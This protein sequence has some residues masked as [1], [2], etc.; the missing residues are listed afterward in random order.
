MEPRRDRGDRRIRFVRR[1]ELISSTSPAGK[2]NL[3]GGFVRKSAESVETGNGAW[4]VATVSLKNGSSPLSD[5]EIT[6]P[7]L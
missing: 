6:V 1:S 5:A 7:D 2:V 4:N 3:N